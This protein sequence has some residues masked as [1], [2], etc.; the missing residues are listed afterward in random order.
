MSMLNTVL[1]TT[2]Q[3]F[4]G[5]ALQQGSSFYYTMLGV[6][7]PAR[8]DAAAALFWLY[9]S[10]KRCCFGATSPEP[11]VAQLH[12]WQQEIQRLQQAE[13]AHPATRLLL[14]ARPLADSVRLTGA[15]QQ[16][17]Q[18]FAAV[19][20]TQP[21]ADTAALQAYLDAT[22]GHLAVG[23]ARL[24]APA[25]AAHGQSVNALRR[26]GA[27][28]ELSSFLKHLG[29]TARTRVE[30]LP[31]PWRRQSGCLTAAHLKADPIPLV[32][33]LR[34][35]VRTA[36]TG[37]LDEVHAHKLPGSG[38]ALVAAALNLQWLKLVDKDPAALLRAR[39][40]LTPLRKYWTARRITRNEKAVFQ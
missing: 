16:M 10:F 27:A 36:L 25:G 7:D 31:L 17:L 11:A 23:L 35:Q 14:Q 12:W 8:R 2:Q 1:K 39:I 18:Q 21:F 4:T 26:L 5:Q 15:L 28:L 29:H 34:Q 24:L 9:K 40:K 33:A 3:E 38:P 13:P 37:A 30:L 19:L 6:T 20:Q 32:D 22:G